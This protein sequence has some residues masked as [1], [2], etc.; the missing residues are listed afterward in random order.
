MLKQDSN[1]DLD[2]SSSKK[3]RINTSQMLFDIER[4]YT[5]S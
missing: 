3:V 2:T 1:Y 5:T 4:H